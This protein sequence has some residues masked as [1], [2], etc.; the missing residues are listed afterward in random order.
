M[1]VWTGFMWPSGLLWNIRVHYEVHNILPLPLFSHTVHINT[2]LA[3]TL[4]SSRWS[5]SFRY[6]DN[7]DLLFCTDVWCSK[8]CSLKMTALWDVALCS[9]LQTD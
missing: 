1:K 3:S 5:L 2:I 4:R 8:Q 6:V 7:Y 9:L